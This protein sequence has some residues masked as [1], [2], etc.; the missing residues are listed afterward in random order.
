MIELY[1]AIRSVL[2]ADPQISGLLSTYK[3]FGASI[4]SDPAPKDAALPY[5]II[6][7]PVSTSA[8]DTK[9]TRGREILLDV[10][11][12]IPNGGDRAKLDA[13]A[14][15]VY[16]LLHRKEIPVEGFKVVIAAASPPMGSP[17]EAFAIGRIV[18]IRFTMMEA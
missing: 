13:I 15:R 9:T 16:T 8:F 5:I 7:D 11:C 10:R 4:F 18:S 12:Y 2:N 1:A 3:S 14:E 17:E 6:S